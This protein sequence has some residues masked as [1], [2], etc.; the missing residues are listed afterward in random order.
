MNCI[1]N[2]MIDRVS[3]FRLFSTCHHNLV[4][5]RGT[6]QVPPGRGQGSGAGPGGGSMDQQLS[7]R[8]SLNLIGA[9]GEEIDLQI[10]L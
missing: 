7:T 1:G 4:V 3:M 5:E 2:N 10:I 6:P 9:A 8:Q